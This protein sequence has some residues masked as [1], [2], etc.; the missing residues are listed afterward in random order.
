MDGVRT[1]AAKADAAF[2]AY[3]NAPR[4]PD[5]EV[6]ADAYRQAFLAY[7]EQG[8]QPLKRMIRC[9]LNNSKYSSP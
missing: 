9:G 3:M 7:R 4:L 1:I 8:I 6:E 2:Q 5:E